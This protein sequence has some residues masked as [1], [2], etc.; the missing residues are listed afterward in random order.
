MDGQ[1]TERSEVNGRKE[2]RK[3]CKRQGSYVVVRCWGTVFE[4]LVIAK[5]KNIVAGVSDTKDQYPSNVVRKNEE[6]KYGARTFIRISQ[7]LGNWTGRARK[8]GDSKT[9][10]LTC[11]RIKQ[12]FRMRHTFVRARIS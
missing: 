3:T 7:W 1:I 2:C 6:K 9:K 8:N 5:K 11:V 10:N 12:V 4:R